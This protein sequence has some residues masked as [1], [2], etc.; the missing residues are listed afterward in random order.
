M[1]RVGD[2]VE[3]DSTFGMM[4]RSNDYVATI[5]ENPSKT[6]VLG[7]PIKRQIAVRPQGSRKAV[8]I[9]AATIRGRV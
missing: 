6:D 1:L 9:D 4:G 2:V 3:V 8:V 7:L 5:V